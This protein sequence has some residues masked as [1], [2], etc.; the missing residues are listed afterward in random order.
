MQDLA[1]VG[2]VESL[3]LG[4]LGIIYGQRTTPTYNY[5]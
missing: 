5:V 1:T 2:G 3:A 4:W